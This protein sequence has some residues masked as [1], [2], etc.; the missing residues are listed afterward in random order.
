MEDLTIRFNNEQE[1][2]FNILFKSSFFSGDFNLPS[3]T[4]IYNKNK[5]QHLYEEQDPDYTIYSSYPD[6]LG[7]R[8]PLAYVSI[9]NKT[10]DKLLWQNY[11]EKL[12]NLIL[13]LQK[14][15]SDLFPESFIDFVYND[16]LTFAAYHIFAK[17]K[18]KFIEMQLEVY[19]NGGFPCGWEG[20][21]PDGKMVVYSPL[22]KEK[23]LL[24]NRLTT[25]LALLA[26]KNIC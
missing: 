26:E 5:A 11:D 21:Y 17:E 20:K 10:K 15:K 8:T 14:E 2:L 13:R 4:I 9:E 18:D 7:D 1:I 24:L 16:F 3:Y 6:L 22:L 25:D 12:W 23:R 19:Q